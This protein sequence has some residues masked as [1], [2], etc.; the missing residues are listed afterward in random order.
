MASPE[1][2]KAMNDR[3]SAEIAE[4]ETALVQR[5]MARTFEVDHE[6]RSDDVVFGTDVFAE[7]L[8]R[9]LDHRIQTYRRQPVA[10]HVLDDAL[11]ETFERLNLIHD[12]MDLPPAVYSS[13][14]TNH[15]H[16]R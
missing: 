1:E 10:G 12:K 4:K 2:T 15:T 9:R 11:A 13:S 16:L 14:E 6:A 8:A 7:L 3:V 5:I